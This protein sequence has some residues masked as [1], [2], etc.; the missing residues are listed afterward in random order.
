MKI[1]YAA[2]EAAPFIKVGGLG[3]VAVRYG[4]H[5]SEPAVLIVTAVL[6]IVIVQVIQ[7]VFNVLSKKMD[8]RIRK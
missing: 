2:S 7:T 1:L 4:Y 3:D 5:R 8:K 6:L